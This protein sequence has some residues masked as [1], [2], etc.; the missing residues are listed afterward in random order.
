MLN[1]GVF[2]AFL[3]ELSRLHLESF[4]DWFLSDNV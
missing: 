2:N 1:L 4:H 3:V